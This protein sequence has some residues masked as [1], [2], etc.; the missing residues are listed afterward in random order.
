MASAVFPVFVSCTGLALLESVR[1]TLPNSRDDTDSE[2]FGDEGTMRNA[3][4]FE[5][6]PPGA[7][8]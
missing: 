4:E 8:V 5:L 7:G 3:N 2:A 1:V 6:P